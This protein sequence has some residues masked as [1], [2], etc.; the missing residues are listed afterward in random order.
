V[1]KQIICFVAVGIAV[2]SQITPATAA[3]AEL[4]GSRRGKN[5]FDLFDLFRREP[6]PRRPNF[7]GWAC[8]AQ[9]TSPPRFR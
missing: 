8:S 6:P 5:R 9:I 1:R 2:A 3:N 7:F 4:P